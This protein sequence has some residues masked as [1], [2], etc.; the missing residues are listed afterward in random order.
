MVSRKFADPSLLSLVDQGRVKPVRE[1][2]SWINALSLL[3]CLDA[4]SWVADCAVYLERLLFRTTERAQSRGQ[5]TNMFSCKCHIYLYVMKLNGCQWHVWRAVVVGATDARARG[6]STQLYAVGSQSEQSSRF[7]A[8]AETQRSYSR[9][10][11]T[12][13][14]LT[15]WV[16]AVCC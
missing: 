9:H 6:G 11:W 2:S 12:A 4:V 5:L 3:L 14:L 15:A 16:L 8:A 10:P 1:F 13:G 7:T